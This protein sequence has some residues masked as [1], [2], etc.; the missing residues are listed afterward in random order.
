MSTKVMFAEDNSA[1]LVVAAKFGAVVTFSKEQRGTTPIKDEETFEDFIPWGESNDFPQKVMEDVDKDTEIGPLLE[2][3]AE[4]LYAGGIVWGIPKL[5]NGEEIL[6]PADDKT[7]TE[8]SLFFD[9][10]NINRYLIEAGMDLVFFYN[11]FPEFVLSRDR[12]KIV[13]LCVQEASYCRWG[14]QN[15]IGFIETCY[16]NANWPD[17]KISDKETVKLPVLDPYYAPADT[18]RETKSGHHFIYP[19]SFPTP[20]KSFY[21]LA[22]WNGLRESGWLEVSQAIPKL[23]KHILENQTRIIYHIEISDLY[24]PSKYKN[25]NE[26][27]DAEKKKA[28]DT[29]IK[30]FTD[31]M[32][33]VENS[34]NSLI[35]GMKTSFDLNKEFSLWKVN[36]VDNKIKKGEFL[37][38]GKE[39]SLNKMSAIGLHPALVGSMP[40]NGMGG[41]GS[42]IREAYNL[43]AILSKTKQD[44]LLEPLKVVRD[45]NGWDPRIQFRIKNAFML[46][47]DKGKE[48]TEKTS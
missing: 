9:R 46:T 26:K 5:E 33:G 40:N 18:L 23:K 16:V 45:Y 1:A 2:K 3:K 36:V 39:A 38:E 10:S 12:S 27:T 37:E 25:W 31:I 34:G 13:Q 41:A 48:T 29:D 15:K 4:L 30:M 6:V 20:G 47:L 42:N 17:A 11:A 8:I 35:T 44:I 24:W 43:N 28:Q 14:K 32:S 21:Q 22:I 19:I 7:N